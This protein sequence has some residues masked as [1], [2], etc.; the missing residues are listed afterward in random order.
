MKYFTI[1]CLAVELLP[2][3]MALKYGRAWTSVTYFLSLP[4]LWFLVVEMISGHMVMAAHLL[5]IYPAPWVFLLITMKRRRN[6]LAAARD[7][8]LRS[9]NLAL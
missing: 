2:L 9:P 3:V 7:E 1:A 8:A 6:Q 5:W 4:A